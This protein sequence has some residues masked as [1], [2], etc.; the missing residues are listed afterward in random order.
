M[1]DG[2]GGGGGPGGLGGMEGSNG[3][4][5]GQGEPGGA[6]NIGGIGAQGLSGEMAGDFGGPTGA[7]GPSGGGPADDLGNYRQRQ[8]R[9]TPPAPPPFQINPQQVQN[10]INSSQW[11]WGTS[12]GQ[13]T[14]PAQYVSEASYSNLAPN[15]QPTAPPFD[16]GGFFQLFG[17]K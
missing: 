3:I 9:I 5:M 12:T 6:G 16:W 1:G 10:D 15:Q 4:G 2:G 11:G 8:Q 14:D 7:S 17:G 13:P